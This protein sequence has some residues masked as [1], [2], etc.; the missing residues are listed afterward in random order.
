MCEDP[1]LKDDV[2][3]QQA[4]VTASM[5]EYGRVYEQTRLNG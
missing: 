4:G 5:A 1:F 2:P 3:Q